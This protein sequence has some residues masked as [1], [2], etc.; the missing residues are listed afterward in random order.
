MMS[1]RTNM[2]ETDTLNLMIQAIYNKN[3]SVFNIA[4]SCCGHPNPIFKQDLVT[5]VTKVHKI[6]PDYNLQKIVS[7][8]RCGE[9]IKPSSTEYSMRLQDVINRVM[10]WPIK[11]YKGNGKIAIRD[12]KSLIERGDTKI[13]GFIVDDLDYRV[14]QGDMIKWGLKRKKEYCW[15][16]K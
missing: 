7:L 11:I 12:S 5:F 10:G 1:R 3:K 2:S 16:P 9:C 14:K 6:F 15:A 8:W 4:C 13:N